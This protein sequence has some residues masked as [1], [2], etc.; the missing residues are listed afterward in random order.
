MADV[1]LGT[2]T[3]PIPS[4]S[5]RM[6]EMVA[7]IRLYL[8]DFP[9]LNRL[10]KGYENSPRQI[11]WSII[12]ALDD[13]NSTP[14]FLGPTTLAR[15]PSEYL[16]CRGAVI[17]LLE[18]VALLQMRNQLTY[19]DGGLQVS[20]SDKA[21]LL[22]QFMSMMKQGY[23]QKKQRFKAAQNVEMAMDGAGVFSEYFIINGVYFTEA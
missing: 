20:V 12:D 9:E 6:N 22:M 10:L 15:F 2:G 18:S 5:A 8:R 23:E 1:L 17:S 19:S 3:T 7:Y 11:A 14:P 16:L 13:W 21:P 4:A